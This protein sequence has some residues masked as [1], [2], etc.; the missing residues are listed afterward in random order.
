MMIDYVVSWQANTRGYLG[1][2]YKGLGV[3]WLEHKAL[4]ETGHGFLLHPALEGNAQSAI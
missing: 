4:V 3:G 1:L 2:A